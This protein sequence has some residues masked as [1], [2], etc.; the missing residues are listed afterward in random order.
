MLML[1]SR[2]H[3]DVVFD[4]PCHRPRTAQ[5]PG[6]Q[7]LSAC[8]EHRARSQPDQTTREERPPEPQA[9]GPNK[10]QH[11]SSAC[12]DNTSHGLAGATLATGQPITYFWSA[13]LRTPLA[14]YAA[15]STPSNLQ[16][17]IPHVG[18]R[19]TQPLLSPRL[20]TVRTSLSSEPPPCSLQHE[21]PP[22]SATRHFLLAAPPPCFAS[23]LPLCPPPCAWPS[24]LALAAIAA[25]LANSS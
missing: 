10:I 13:K 22:T 1:G 6:R 20:R 2:S 23:P 7:T 4:Q 24:L 17:L 14:A 11:E 21:P 8:I 5:L 25:R 3:T 16:N 12:P 18:I 9:E 19:A 15:K